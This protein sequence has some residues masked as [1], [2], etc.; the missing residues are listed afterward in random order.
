MPAAPRP[1]FKKPTK[2]W[3]WSIYRGPRC[4][5]KTP[6]WISPRS[7]PGWRGRMWM[8]ARPAPWPSPAGISGLRCPRACPVSIRAAGLRGVL[9]AL[10]YHGAGG[11]HRRTA[12]GRPR[13]AA[14]LRGPWRRGAGCTRAFACPGTG[15]GRPSWRR[16]AGRMRAFACIRAA[17][18]AIMRGN[19][20]AAFCRGVPNM[21]ML[22]TGEARA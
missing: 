14:R 3:S 18:F 21:E 10:L 11:R 5:V 6:T 17:R 9:A 2:L 13:R 7:T 1:V 8:T 15:A 20:G 22:Q 19:G 4:G 12:R 16:G